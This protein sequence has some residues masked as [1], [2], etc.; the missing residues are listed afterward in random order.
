M[1]LQLLRNLLLAD[2][3]ACHESS[4]TDVELTCAPYLSFISKLGKHS[5]QLS[6]GVVLLVDGQLGAWLQLLLGMYHADVIDDGN[7]LLGIRQ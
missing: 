4:Q 2:P 3:Q 7:L 1:L 6:M 5:H